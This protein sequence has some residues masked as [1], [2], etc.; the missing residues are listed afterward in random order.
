MFYNGTWGTVCGEGYPFRLA[1]QTCAMLGYSYYKQYRFSRSTAFLGPPMLWNVS[2]EGKE[3][4]FLDCN[5]AGWHNVTPQCE[6]HTQ[7]LYITC[8][9]TYSKIKA[10]LCCYIN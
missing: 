2:C 7:D 10:L 9:S 5:S 8:N 6:D 1:R 3:S 4:N